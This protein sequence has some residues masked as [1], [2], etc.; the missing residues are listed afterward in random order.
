[1]FYMW[2]IIFAYNSLFF[3]I[4][5]GFLF[6]EKRKILRH[7][8]CPPFGGFPPCLI[9]FSNFFENTPG[10]FIKELFVNKRN[11]FL[12]FWMTTLM[13]GFCFESYD[14][15]LNAPYF[16]KKKVSFKSKSP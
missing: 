7:E 3:Y 12:L 6:I 4:L 10:L 8:S 14:F 1:M 15:L 5:M 2:F 9:F 11:I 16:F 13:S